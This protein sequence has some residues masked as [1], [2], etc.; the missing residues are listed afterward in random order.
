M[1]LVVLINILSFRF[2]KRIDLT[3]EKRYSLSE[4]SKNILR[5]LSQTV[6]IEVFLKGQFPAGFKRLTNATKEF[7]DE[8]ASYANGKLNISYTD[9][10]KGLD[11]ST[12]TDFIDSIMYFYD[13]APTRLGDLQ[14]KV[15]E[16][17]NS[18]VVLPGAIVRCNDKIAGVSLLRGAR[19]MGTEEEE[20]AK[21]YS[22]VESG[23]EY[24][25]INAIH[26]VSAIK[27]PSIGYALG[28]GEAWGYNID[29]AFQTLRGKSLQTNFYR[30]DTVNIPKLPFIPESI[31]ALI[32]LKPTKSFSEY[33][34]LKIDQYVMRGG[35]IFWM[36]DNMYA[37]FDSLM[38]VSDK[39]FI[40]F[41]RGLNIDDLLFKYGVRINQNLLQDLQSDHLPLVA[42]DA[43]N[44]GQQQ[45][46]PFSFMPILNGTQHPITKYLDGIRALFPNTLDTIKTDGVRKTILL[47]SSANARIINTPFKVDFS[48]LEFSED[49]SRF[50]VKD[51]SVAALLEGNFP[52]FFTNRLSSVFADSLK[53]IN[54]PFLE[55]PV[56]PGK[57]IV[58]ADGDIATNMVSQQSGPLKM[59][60]NNYTHV[61]F[62]NKDFYLNCI[63]Y[64]TGD[65]SLL[66]TRSK[67]FTPRFLDPVKKEDQSGKWKVLTTVLPITV[68]LITGM[69]Y[70]FF[71]KRI[72]VKNLNP[73]PQP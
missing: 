40:A 27:K 51:T 31:D 48:F 50:T 46:V 38:R 2:F 68:L 65:S 66:Q 57:M 32:I 9:P 6:H 61:T 5:N 26:K 1:L 55:N 14:T 3:A 72:F 25:F 17:T 7:L 64:L 63:E 16:E 43:Q 71:R 23:L 36:I 52:S 11:D 59:G 67:E 35:N 12:A 42:G 10:L 19:Q 73:A 45:L 47:R 29:D 4:S 56:R 21:M 28:N 54:R 60:E 15:T 53:A 34:K 22:L 24:K 49:K 70:G 20:L 44:G 37:E 13:I 62:A 58:V 8:C 39:G 18:R 33:D 30:V 69:L 41:D